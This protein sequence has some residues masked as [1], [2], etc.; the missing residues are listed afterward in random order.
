MPT[1]AELHGSQSPAT[2]R[3]KPNRHRAVSDMATNIAERFDVRESNRYERC[4]LSAKRIGSAEDRESQF[5]TLVVRCNASLG[6][7]RTVWCLQDSAGIGE[8]TFV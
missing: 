8:S 4:G 6:L 3:E 2:S 7:I 5:Q 1:T